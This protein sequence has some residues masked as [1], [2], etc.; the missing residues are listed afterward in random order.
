MD[1]TE[2]RKE[3]Y[4]T[5]ALCGDTTR[6]LFPYFGELEDLEDPAEGQFVQEFMRETEETGL[7]RLCGDCA[8]KVEA[9]FKD[10]SLQGTLAG[11][12]I[13]FY[14]RFI[15]DCSEMIDPAVCEVL[16][17]TD[18][19]VA[20]S[21]F[22]RDEGDIV[23]ALR[24]VGKPVAVYVFGARY[25]GSDEV[26]DDEDEQFIVYGLDDTQD[27]YTIDKIG[28]CDLVKHGP[29]ANGLDFAPDG[30]PLASS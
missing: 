21:R 26:F 12:L 28:H 17:D 8:L 18:V 27:S 14:G 3:F 15:K 11:A 5:C 1:E 23:E 2:G 24:R 25:W 20:H 19:L 13:R 29:F 6:E 16:P 30:S 4:A 22:V 9:P 7:E 10:R